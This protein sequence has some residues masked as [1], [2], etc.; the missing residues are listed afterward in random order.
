MDKIPNDLLEPTLSAES[1][2]KPIYSTQAGFLLA[3]LGGGLAITFFSAL[4][5]ER[6][7]RLVRDLPVY[8]L[9]IGVIAGIMYLRV[10][11]PHLFEISDEDGK[12]TSYYIV[13][14]RAVGLLLWGSYYW[15]HSKHYRVMAV[16]G[17]PHPSP[18]L[19]AGVCYLA[20]IGIMNFAL[21]AMV[22]QL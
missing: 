2:T 14:V 10:T 11:Q 13:A 12:T 5:S 18:W 17:T 19:A 6:L 22:A 8:L 20:G 3:F 15:L 1:A 9:G 21:R 16:T 4:N 7:G